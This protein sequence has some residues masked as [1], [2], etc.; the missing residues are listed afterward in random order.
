L[1]L[2]AAVLSTSILIAVMGGRF[3]E[4]ERKAYGGGRKPWWFNLGGAVYA[5]FYIAVL[6]A[7]IM[8]DARTWAAWV[9]V[10]FIPVAAVTKGSLVIFNKK[11]QEK[12]TSIEGNENWR[13]VALTRLIL[14]PLFL[15]LAFY[16]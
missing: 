12:V 4:V 3:Q 9:L 11:G 16:A 5:V 8:S 7:F 2:A 13:K 14:V 15:V 1:A 6:V 10:V